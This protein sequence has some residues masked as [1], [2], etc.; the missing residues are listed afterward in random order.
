MNEDTDQ[1]TAQDV[2]QSSELTARLL[3]RLTASPGIIDIQMLRQIPARLMGLLAPL[4]SLFDDLIARY[5][6]DDGSMG[7]QPLIMGQPWMQNVNAYLTN[8]N[9]LSSTTNQFISIT[10]AEQ[11]SKA[12]RMKDERMITEVESFLP[13]SAFLLPSGSSSL[14]TPTTGSSRYA[15]NPAAS[16]TPLD[17]ASTYSPMET[18]RVN[19]RP[20]QRAWES[21]LATAQAL[22]RNPVLKPA[23][24]ST[25]AALA[26]AHIEDEHQPDAGEQ[27]AVSE[28]ASLKSGLANQTEGEKLRAVKADEK[29]E[30]TKAIAPSVATPI[31]LPLAQVQVQRKLPDD[32]ATRAE[33]ISKAD[34]LKDERQ[35]AESIRPTVTAALK[36]GLANHTGEVKKTGG[37]FQPV[38]AKAAALTQTLL[39]AL[40][41][42][43]TAEGWHTSDKQS[44]DSDKKTGMKLKDVSREFVDH[45]SLRSNLESFDLVQKQA[46]SSQLQ[47]RATDFVWRRSADIPT[48]RDLT[49]II[50]SASLLE[51]AR[52]TVV[53]GSLVQS[54]QSNQ[55]IMPESMRRKNEIRAGSRLTTERIVRN[56][57]R[58]LLIERERRGY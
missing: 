15:P 8:Y 54:P 48:V 55:T 33:R 9:S 43:R 38:P 56:I 49:T 16:S 27:S 24:V 12:E 13:P 50:S 34:E 11:K 22:V 6:I 1:I 21:T 26:A 20:A 51:A 3:R 57:S 52:R 28:T 36:S 41:L 31:N 47:K 14:S 10:A 45:S 32:G 40:H 17:K 7:S 29:I 30:P 35:P 42:N 5:G 2:L 39:T 25:S 19:R 46:A 53:A 58:K 37:P 23:D 4:V 44:T 18:F